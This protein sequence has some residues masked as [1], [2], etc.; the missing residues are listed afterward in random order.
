M[1]VIVSDKM[2]QGYCYRRVARPG[3]D[4]APGFEPQLTPREMLELGVFEGHYLTDC[5][6]EF[7]TEWF[8]K[9]RLNPE[10]PDITCNCFHVKSRQSLSQWRD[11]GWIYPPDPRGWFQWYCRY[12]MG[13][14][15]PELDALQIRRWRAFRRHLA[16]VE[17]ACPPMDFTCRPRQRQALLQ[18]AYNPFI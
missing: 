14:R 12:Y 10:R 8:E 9:A 6:A 5:R 15:I 2:Q 17:H 11:N 1:P 13:R 7:P 16:Q 18:W 4:F 3:Q